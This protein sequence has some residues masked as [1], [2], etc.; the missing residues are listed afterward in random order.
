MDE[1]FDPVAAG[2]V[3][4]DEPP[5]DPTAHGA[6]PVQQPEKPSIPALA[7]RTAWDVIKQV[8]GLHQPT[9]L[10]EVAQEIFPTHFEN[11][12]V[13]GMLG[14]AKRTFEQGIAAAKTPDFSPEKFAFAGNVVGQAGGQLLG[15]LGLK[16]EPA[17]AKTA[18]KLAEVAE[19]LIG[20][21]PDI[22]QPVEPVAAQE[23]KVATEAA[24]VP[25]TEPPIVPEPVA[26]PVPAA[27]E[28]TTNVLGKQEPIAPTTATGTGGGQDITSLLTEEGLN[29]AV[30][31]KV[32][33]TL[34]QFTP[35]TNVRF[36][37]PRG[38]SL[39]SRDPTTGKWRV[40]DFE[41]DENGN[42]SPQR[43]D[44]FDSW[45]KA[46]S[47]EATNL[48]TKATGEPNAIQ[49]QSAG[50]I[51]QHPQEGT[52]ATGSERV[53]VEPSVQ[54][55]TPTGTRSEGVT[56]ATTPEVT[57]EIPEGAKATVNF[58]TSSGKLVPKEM[59][60]REAEG[61]FTKEKSSYQALLNCLGA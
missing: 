10:S 51:L 23:A 42:L 50:S 7:G 41:K 53:G 61:I 47:S 4:V 2:A 27:T 60:A 8:T 56:G 9:S 49:E 15:L 25:A 24:P 26:Q 5:F 17:I 37:S 43:H 21:A 52:T 16:A 6:I 35:E 33:R 59:D 12:L 20:K 45:E 30:T 19:P 1:P 32:Q 14:G 38:E 22:A 11:T 36:T 29:Q 46:V 57:P 31:N 39:V 28:A 18:P 44:L 13:G 54:G 48:N 34:Q 3:A 58:K 40:T 55:E